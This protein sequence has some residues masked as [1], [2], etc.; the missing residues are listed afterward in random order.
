MKVLKKGMIG[1]DV[2]TLQQSLGITA[3]GIFGTQTENAVKKWQAENGLI[4][5]GIVGIKTWTKLLNFKAVFTG[6]VYDPLKV[7]ITK[8]PNRSI[9]YIAI[10]YTA[11]SS[12]KPGSA[13]K[14]K[15]VFESRNASADFVVDDEQIVQFNEDLN[16]YYC[17]AVGDQKNMVSKGGSLYGKATNKNTISIEICSNLKCG[18]SASIPNHEGWY[19]TSEALKN[20]AEL[21]K[22]LMEEYNIPFE[23]VVRHYDISGKMCPGIIGWN[24]EN[25]YTTAGKQTKEK[26]NSKEWECFK[27]MLK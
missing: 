15:N 4:A 27:K 3:D 25:I 14:V 5:D 20:A 1:D 24:N 19:F 26:S 2:K 22:I 13:L 21:C 9:K 11:G 8:S 18:T 17:W 7:H 6:V 23:N 16:N 10:H 12:S